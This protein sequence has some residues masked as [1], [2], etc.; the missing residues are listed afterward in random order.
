MK[1]TCLSS[2]HERNEALNL[3]SI[4][5]G[6]NICVFLSHLVGSCETFLFL[7]VHLDSHHYL[8]LASLFTSSSDILI[9]VFPILIG[10]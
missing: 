1:A 6:W 3:R 10:F 8:P 2:N 7:P 5:V 4:P 9:F